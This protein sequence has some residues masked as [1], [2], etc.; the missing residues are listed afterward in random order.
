MAKIIALPKLHAISV[1]NDG[2]VV[3]KKYY[4]TALE[5]AQ[6]FVKFV[7]HGDADWERVVTLEKPDGST[8]VKTFSRIGLA[9]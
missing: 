7:D 1:A 3:W 8:I 2:E 5:A 9:K 4:D 6:D